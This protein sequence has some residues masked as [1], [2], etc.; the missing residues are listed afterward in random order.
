MWKSHIKILPSISLQNSQSETNQLSF[1]SVTISPFP[2]DVLCLSP[3]TLPV[4]AGQV[5]SIRYSI[6]LVDRTDLALEAAPFR[7]I[8]P[9]HPLHTCYLLYTS[10]VH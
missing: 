6:T 9:G 7:A 2:P 5:W 1:V 3:V 4:D 10:S 8:N